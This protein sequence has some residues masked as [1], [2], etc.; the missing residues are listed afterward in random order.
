M[1]SVMTSKVVRAIN[2]L[3]D[4]RGNWSCYF[5]TPVRACLS[6]FLVSKVGVHRRTRCRSG[7]WHK[8]SYHT[9]GKLREQ[10]WRKSYSPMAVG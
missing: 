4:R 5:A 2:E 1:T 8:D 3:L 9:Q 7:G 6:L 10:L